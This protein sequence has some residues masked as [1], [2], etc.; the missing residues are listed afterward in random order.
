MRYLLLAL[1]LVAV[2]CC[3][4]RKTRVA[5][6]VAPE[7]GGKLNP[8]SAESQLIAA[9]AHLEMGCPTDATYHVSREGS[10]YHVQVKYVAGYGP[11]REPIHAPN[12]GAL[13]VLNQ[14]GKLVRVDRDHLP[15]AADPEQAVASDSQPS[16]SPGAS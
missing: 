14:E 1:L 10:E 4:A 12:R 6:T 11:K 5:S 9:R 7:T 13:V 15:G 2:P 16:P 3:A 8:D